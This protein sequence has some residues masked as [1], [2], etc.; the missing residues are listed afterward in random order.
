MS[1]TS[2]GFLLMAGFLSQALGA[3]FKENDE[4]LTQARVI[5][6][7]AACREVS[8][9]TIDTLDRDSGLFVEGQHVRYAMYFETVEDARL[10][11]QAISTITDAI[12]G[13]GNAR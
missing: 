8:I 5:A 13:E 1:A 6:G 9:E 10:F 12:T 11:D 3:L 7:L 2:K 4:I